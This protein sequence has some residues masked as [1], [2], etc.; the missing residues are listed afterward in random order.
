MEKNK[1]LHFKTYEEAADWFESA[2][3]TEYEDHLSPVEF[4]FDL[5]KSRDFVG[6]IMRS[7]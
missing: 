4:S 3:M 1:K 7:Q 6:S 5:R 2:E